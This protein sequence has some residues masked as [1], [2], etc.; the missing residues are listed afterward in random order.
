MY[1]ELMYKNKIIELEEKFLTATREL[2][3]YREEKADR[4]AELVIAD[5]ELIYQIGEKADRAAELVI[6]DKE[7][8][9]QTGEKAD[10]AAE[11]LIANKELVFQNKEKEKRAA[12]LLI[13]NIQLVRENQEKEK[14]AAELLI[15]KDALF[16]EKQLLEKTLISI[17]DAVIC[18]DNH[19][20]V[21][22][23]NRVAESIT[24]WIQKEAFGTSVYDI[25]NIFDEFT[26][27]KGE[28]IVKKVMESGEIHQLANHTVLLAK[29][30]KEFLIEDSAAP[31]LDEINKVVGVVI[32]FR[33]YTEKWERLKKI[34]FIGLHDELTGIYNRRFFEEEMVRMDTKRNL[35]L[36]IIMGDV[37]GLKLV[38]DS[39]G[40][41][42][43]DDLL[44]KAANAIKLGCRDDDIVARIGGDEFVIILPNSDEVRAMEVVSRICSIMK[45]KKIKGIPIS[46]SFGHGTKLDSTQNL[47]NIFKVAE[48]HLYQ[49]KLYESTSMRNETIKLISNTL[50]AK[51]GREL[52]HSQKVSELCE[53]LSTE[54]GFEGDA[55]KLM[56]LAG[57]MH[58]IGKIGMD[59]KIL[60]K[61]GRLTDDEYVEVKKHPEIGYRILSS[62]NEFSE[63]SE[64]VL[65]HHEKWDGTGYPRG[66]KG[67]S[68]DIEARIIGVADAFAAMTNERTYGTIRSNEEAALE[69]KRCSGTQFDPQIAKVFVQKVL[70]EKW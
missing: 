55:I 41:K 15:L 14:R 36:S 11:L 62:V 6:A 38:N 21:T 46:V 50:H 52:I 26:R 68:I 9:Y 23:I 5:K 31:I 35:P 22:F 48:D 16:N 7:L 10:R 34:E 43:G 54:L 4:A 12:E 67:D 56:K 25:F 1:D 63:I 27:T 42:I 3:E 65:Q 53:A 33:D 19:Y 17:G 37:N 40:H 59:D 51:N 69:I 60:N 61:C 57:L 66:L 30:G 70:K 39:F 44:K 13:A 32:V 47:R 24:G 64:Y 18:T 2:M 20:K 28:D 45:T 58:D 49:H 29:S 8:V